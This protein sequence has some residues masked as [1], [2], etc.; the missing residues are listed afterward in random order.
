MTEDWRIFS[1][2]GDKNRLTII[3]RLSRLGPQNMGKLTEGLSISR[4][5]GAK[6]IDILK[7]VGLVSLRKIGRDQVVELQRENLRLT[8]MY[9]AQLEATW[10]D[11]LDLLK[12]LAEEDS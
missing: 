1:A 9:M 2:L 10:D 4:Q 11:R 6:H 8:R 7:E 12:T 5:A 3:E